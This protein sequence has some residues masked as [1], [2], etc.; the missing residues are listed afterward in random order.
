M[1]RFEKFDDDLVA[2]LVRAGWSPNR[3]VDTS[4]WVQSLELEGYR[5]HLAA[6]EVLASM[7]GLVVPPVNPIGPNFENGDPLNFD[8]IAAGAAYREMALEIEEVL[9]GSY[10]PI[11]EWLSYSSVFM[12][13][14]GR[15]VATGMGW[16]WGLGE[17]FEEA[18]RLA[19]FSDR[20][21]VCL[22]TG[23]GLSPWPPEV[24]DGIDV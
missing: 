21:L 10:F 8:P 3:D 23:P 17:T 11:G 19:I 5:I 13:S 12:E 2:A 7:G 24:G 4:A 20:P 1:K 14:G 6:E 22:H 15:V 9:G 16:I 18:L